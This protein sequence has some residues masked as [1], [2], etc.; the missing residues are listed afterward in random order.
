MFPQFF[1]PGFVLPEPSIRLLLVE[2]SEDDAALLARELRRSGC[3]V[4]CKRVDNPVAFEAALAS[5]P[6]D[7]I[8]GDYRLPTFTGLDA[9]AVVRGRGLDVPFILLSGVIGGE[10]AVQAMKAGANDYI[11]KD[12]L[13]RLVPAVERE[14][15]E[16][17]VRRER[18]RT[19]EALW[20]ESAVTAALARVAG[21][22]ITLLDTPQI[23]DQLCRLTAEVL[24]CD[25]VHA[26]LWRGEG[27]VYV[28]ACGYGD[29]AE[30]WEALRVWRIPKATVAQYL[31]RLE[32][33]E[34]AEVPS[35][36]PWQ[37]T[38]T[39]V[40]ALWVA[41]RRGS[42]PIGLLSASHRR[43]PGSFTARQKRIAR[44]INQLASMALANAR[45]V[46]ELAHANRVKE[47]FVATMSHEL[48]TPLNVILGYHDLLIGGDF[49]PLTC[50]QIEPLQH[51]SRSAHEL[52]ELITATLDLS[53]IEAG[54]PPAEIKDVCPRDL[55]QEVVAET[56]RN[57][58]KPAVALLWEASPRLPRLMTDPLKLKIVIKNLVSNAIKFTDR[59]SVMIDVRDCHSG[60]AISVI[61]T[62]IGIP[63]QTLPF[64]FEPFR[65][66][67]SSS[68]RRHGGVG[69]GLYIVQR[70]T[71]VLGATLSVDSIVD[72][73]STFRMWVPL[74]QAAARREPQ[75][76]PTSIGNDF[77][78][79]GGTAA[80]A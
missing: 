22:L 32:E 77:L 52:V 72:R 41:L 80:S 64:I 36:G 23:L 61:D 43:A 78:R 38:N 4:T 20:E 34:V 40:S 25:S 49:G 46:E 47:D 21:A 53:R 2:D 27:G 65:Q 37:P 45:L 57:W 16:A 7:I 31:S 5:G 14:L 13:A 42:E 60:I 79:H 11:M 73:G 12:N 63:P 67:D 28:P 33:N 54:R 6:W 50:E 56:E 71:D 70:L 1:E 51:A 68:T 30:Q 62:G 18:K 9:L 66:G 24:E 75:P 76:A 69:L 19:E 55:I 35:A 48:R 74:E 15:R 58:K 59:G 10:L 17:E 39:T 8:I 3:R 29:T 44:G 26:F